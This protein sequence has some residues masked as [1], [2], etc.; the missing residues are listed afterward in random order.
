MF[1]LTAAGQSRC[2]CPWQMHGP[3]LTPPAIWALLGPCC[4]AAGLLPRQ[5][6]KNSRCFRSVELN[7]GT[8]RSHCRRRQPSAPPPQP[9]PC[10]IHTTT[11]RRL[12]PTPTPDLPPNH[13]P[14]STHK[15]Q[16]TIDHGGRAHEIPAAVA[17]LGA[18]PGPP[19][20]PGHLADQKRGHPHHLAQGQG[21]PAAGREAH[22]T[23]QEERRGSAEEST[24]DSL[25]PFP[26]PP[27]SLL[28]CPLHTPTNN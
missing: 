26:P 10:S 17:R 24:G 4:R 5:G 21:G 15:T 18:P 22:H 27:P 6:P 14:S 3:S 25:R 20:Q 7:R 13:H 1:Q 11:S 28:A 2:C 8:T 23:R 12:A 19:P 16:P 9:T